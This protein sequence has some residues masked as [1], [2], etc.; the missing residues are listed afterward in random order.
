MFKITLTAVLMG[1]C[2]GLA[3]PSASAQS[4]PCT[5]DMELTKKT[6]KSCSCLDSTT[7]TQSISG[8][9]SVSVG[10]R[11]GGS[12]GAGG[13]SISGESSASTTVT[14]GTAQSLSAVVNA[15]ECVQLLL[16]FSCCLTD[17]ELPSGS[18]LG[19]GAPKKIVLLHCE[20]PEVKMIAAPPTTCS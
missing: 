10:S 11:V 19:L 6:K 12:V 2:L 15:G 16:T 7:I 5:P 17:L 8:A 3:G 13:V 20:D 9:V 1:V 18:F 14:L 4:L